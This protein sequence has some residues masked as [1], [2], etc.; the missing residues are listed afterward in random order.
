MYPL[1]TW[2]AGG[3]VV[4]G[5]LVPGCLVAIVG[6]SGPVSPPAQPA[7]HQVVPASEAGLTSVIGKARRGAFVGLEPTSPREFQVPE[8]PVVMD[9]LGKAFIPELLVARVGQP[10]EF[11]NSEDIPHNVYV[12]RSRT[13]RE[14]LNVSTDPAQRHTHV[15][16]EAGQYDVSC[17]IHPGMLASVFVVATPYAAVADASGSFLILNV[18]PGSYRLT[19]TNAGEDMTRTVEVSGSHTDVGSA[20]P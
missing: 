2:P 11:R 6:C 8:A 4:T 13:G 7:V 17:D 3:A 1:R 18:P 12:K 9:Q 19:A 15:F 14:V 16:T 20:E 5:W 10:V